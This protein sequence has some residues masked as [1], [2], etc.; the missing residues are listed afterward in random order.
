MR[1]KSEAK[2][3]YKYINQYAAE[4][5]DRVV[6]LLPKGM[7][8]RVLELAKAKGQSVSAYMAGLLPSGLDQNR[9]ELK[10]E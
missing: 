8:G 7:K 6:V 3:N 2:P 9:E 4:H 10:E 5:Y 1:R